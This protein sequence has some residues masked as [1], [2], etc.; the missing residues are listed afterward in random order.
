[1][2]ERLKRA[3]GSEDKRDSTVPPDVDFVVEGEGSCPHAGLY[4]ARRDD[5]R[6][7][8]EADALDELFTR[9]GLDQILHHLVEA[10][11]IRPY[12]EFMLASQLRLTELLAPR[13]FKLLDLAKSR[14]HFTDPVDLYVASNGQINAFALHRLSEGSPHAISLASETVRAMNDDELCFVFGHE[15]GHLKYE[16]YRPKMVG[17]ILSLKRAQD[18]QRSNQ[19]VAPRLLERRMERW[20]RLAEITADRVGLHACGGKLDAAVS[21]FFR[22]SSGL[23]PE[24][25]CYDISGFLSQLEQLQKMARPEVLARFSHPVT[26]VRARALQRWH[27]HRGGG[28]SGKPAAALSREVDAEIASLT[29]LMEYEASSEMGIQARELLVAA[30]LLAAHSDGHASEEEENVMVQLLLQVTGDPE[31]HIGKL[32][33]LEHA[34]EVLAKSAAWLRENAG[35]ERFA[36]FGQI[37]HVV[38]VDGR[39]SAKEGAFMMDLAR[40]LAIPERAAREM[41]HEILSNYVQSK[42][43]AAGLISRLD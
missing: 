41:I 24:H 26:P 34:R 2:F 43:G 16:H 1:M 6:F 12:H 19:E 9:F 39:V 22:M 15:L 35:Q 7:T 8:P 27:D 11:E 21:A 18:A 42:T 28:G 4:A 31:A 5:I 23:G 10:D 13:L 30:G 17:Q 33:T 25:L 14:L 38:A 32:R 37:A 40:L 3:L 36:L 20:G 29:Q